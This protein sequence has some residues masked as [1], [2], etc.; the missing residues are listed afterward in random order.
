MA[1]WLLCATAMLPFMATAVAGNLCEQGLR[2]SPIDIVAPVRHALPAADFRYRPAALK[3][4][5]DGH[6]VRVRYAN[7]SH[8]VLGKESY[9]LQQFHFH[10]PGGDR[11]AG[12]EF[13]MAA[14]LIHKNKAGHLMVVVVLF[15]K[16][17]EN[18]LLGELLPR[19]PPKPDGDHLLANVRVDAARLLPA[20]KDYFAYE[21]SLTAPPCTEGVTWLV[22]KQVLELSP[23]QL[24]SYRRL[25]A[26]NARA[27][28]PLH[29][30]VVRESK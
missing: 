9:A 12:E 27:V 11:I 16:G 30:R 7:E 18:T 1:S 4:A 29:G 8:L 26:D 6:T 5:N 13:D 14:H 25:F 20:R 19:I 3:I 2:Q 17:A 15:R 24:V 22:M 10:T 23:D 28:Q 21:G